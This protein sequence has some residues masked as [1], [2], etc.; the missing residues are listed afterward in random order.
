MGLKRIPEMMVQSRR[1]CVCVG[2][3]PKKK[4]AS[5]YMHNTER[6]VRENFA[7][8]GRNFTLGNNVQK[9]NM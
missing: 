1:G 3:C 6:L 2:Q 8:Y 5:I 9:E 7:Q 4:G